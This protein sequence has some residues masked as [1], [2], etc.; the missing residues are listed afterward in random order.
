MKKK[1]NNKNAKMLNKKAKQNN[2]KSDYSVFRDDEKTR[3][4]NKIDKNKINENKIDRN[5]T[6]KNKTEQSEIEKNTNKKS[7][8]KMKLS[9]AII[10]AVI[11]L[12]Y[13]IYGVAKLV[14]N[15]TNT[16]MVTNG[17]ISQEESEIGYIV[18]D[19]KVVK[20]K[21]YKNGM[22]KI[23]NE[24]E[25]VAKGDS[26][27]RY[28]SSGENDLKSQIADLDIKIQ[29]V[30]QNEKGILPSDVK[31][32][33]N[34]IEKEL[35]SIYGISNVQNI[36]EY[37]KNI[38]T[39][40]TKK[41]KI[42]GELSPSGSYLKQLLSQREE[43]ED[44]LNSDSEYIEAPESGIV[45]YRVDGLEEVLT[46]ENFANLNKEFL[47]KL[48]IKTGQT[49]A[50][51]EEVGKIINNFHC[52]IVFNSNSKE[53]KE[54]K[55]GN[56]I[57]IRLQNSDVVKAEI[58]NIIEEKDGSRTITVK[59]TGDVEKLA[60]YRKISF[61]IIW[62]DA[63]GFRIPNEAIRE[64]NGLS[65]VVRNRNGYY[66][67][68]LVK[69]LRKNDEYCIVKQ[70]KTEELQELGFTNTQIYSMK[71]IALYDEIVINPTEE[72]MLQ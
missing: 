8:K 12:S 4:T 61:D 27:F 40:I 37:K 58:E 30:M 10:L 32:L 1:V 67:K 15:P 66:N 19:E 43:L 49:I 54:T 2:I 28:Y 72:Q 60:A 24:G 55:V 6:K 21:N 11:V 14:K 18:R 23:K 44:R 42:S 3:I 57:K 53:S 48:D 70:Y 46:T 50:S 33:E 69:I 13:A 38:N 25:K 68:M 17:K 34:Q 51:S 22:V 7:I 62:W 71:N 39:Y 5:K 45:S 36:Q 35:N 9:I 16:F 47:E 52:Y 59:I 29:E 64:E 41:A 26:I 20:E 56:T 31:L 65:Y 63:E